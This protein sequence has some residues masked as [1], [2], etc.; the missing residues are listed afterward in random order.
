M[1]TGQLKSEPQEKLW[2][3]KTKDKAEKKFD[4][5]KM[6]REIRDRIDR[7]TEGMN[8]DQLK[9]YY[10]QSADENRKRSTK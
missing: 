1:V 9:K 2:I 6:M 4:A 8:F 5:V 3:M 10:E 7:E